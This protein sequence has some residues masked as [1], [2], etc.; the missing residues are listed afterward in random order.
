MARSVQSGVR[1]SLKVNSRRSH[2]RTT[3]RNNTATA[4]HRLSQRLVQPRTLQNT[5]VNA[6]RLTEG[7]LVNHRAMIRSC[8]R[9]PIDFRAGNT[10]T[11]RN[12]RRPSNG[13]TTRSTSSKRFANVPVFTIFSPGHIRT[14]PLWI[15]PAQPQCHISG[16][17]A[18]AIGMVILFHAFPNSCRRLHAIDICIVICGSL[19]TGRIAL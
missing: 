7:T 6:V 1:S 18:I 3:R 13:A 8:S 12:G 2:S 4:T 16:L 5:F 15:Q 17:R 9:C 10:L 19:I 11:P 14:V